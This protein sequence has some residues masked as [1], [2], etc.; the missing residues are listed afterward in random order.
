MR[1]VLRALLV[2]RHLIL[3]VAIGVG[4]LLVLF[5]TALSRA[6]PALRGWVLRR[7]RWLADVQRRRCAPPVTSLYATD[8]LAERRDLAWLGA[9]AAL[10]PAALIVLA[11]VPNGVMGMLTPVL[12]V[13]TPEDVVF[14][15]QAIPIPD[16]GWRSWS[17]PRTVHVVPGSCWPTLFFPGR[18]GSNPAVVPHQSALAGRAFKN[19]RKPGGRG[20]PLPAKFRGSK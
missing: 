7:T 19:W 2:G 18:V 12:R 1:L 8:D 6:R 4:C 13:F 3:S 17:T 11:A 16:H 10:T 5:A 14:Y 15:F 20:Q 9:Q